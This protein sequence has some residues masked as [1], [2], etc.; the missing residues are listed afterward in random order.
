MSEI[1]CWGGFKV[2][3]TLDEFMP[4]SNFDGIRKMNV[5]DWLIRK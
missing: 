5:I 3:L 1:F 2:L 4:N